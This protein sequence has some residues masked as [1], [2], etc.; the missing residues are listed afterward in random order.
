[1]VFN[2]IQK[3]HDKKQREEVKKKTIIRDQVIEK[4]FSI[5]TPNDIRNKIKEAINKERLPSFSCDYLLRSSLEE[6]TNQNYIE[7]KK[8]DEGNSYLLVD[9]DFHNIKLDD[10]DY[11]SL[12]PVYKKFKKELKSDFYFKINGRTEDGNIRI[13]FT[14]VDK[15]LLSRFFN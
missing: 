3:F 7:V 4:F 10:Y 2:D 11:L 6:G 13:E 9:L 14:K 1:M 5:H 15:P 8:Q 12:S